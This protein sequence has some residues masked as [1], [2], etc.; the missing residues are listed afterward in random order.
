ME[1]H[2][3]NRARLLIVAGAVAAL[4]ILIVVVVAAGGGSEPERE[5]AAAP[6]ECLD[7]WNQDLAQTNFG[8]HQAISH[9]YTRVQVAYSSAD[10]SEVGAEPIP[11]G[12]CA[13]VFA[14][15]RL[16]PEPGAAAQIS[17]RSRW[18]PLSNYADPTRLA[19]LQSQALGAANAELGADGMLAAL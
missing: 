8:R 16:D 10:G 6:R 4:A 1:S 18:E 11:G 3:D 14:A 17:L 19:Q 13:V 9:G 5:F 12:G 15:T 7:R 2:A